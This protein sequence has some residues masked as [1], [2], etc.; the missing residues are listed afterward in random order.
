[1]KVLQLI[2]ALVGK[3]LQM[4][5]SEGEEQ[6]QVVGVL[7][8]VLFEVGLFRHELGHELL[9][10]SGALR[11]RSCFAQHPREDSLQRFSGVIVILVELDQ[12]CN[13]AAKFRYRSGGEFDVG[14]LTIRAPAS[15][16]GH[17]VPPWQSTHS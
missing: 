12:I 15:A 13:E 8:D 5:V 1:M 10:H 4:G 14:G 3:L 2:R 6:A 17:A 11:F 9:K 7:E 16:V